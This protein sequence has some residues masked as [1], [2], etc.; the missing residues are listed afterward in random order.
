[1]KDKGRTSANSRERRTKE[2]EKLVKKMEKEGYAKLDMF[3][4]LQII[5]SGIVLL[6]FVNLFFACNFIANNPVY[7]LEMAKFVLS[8]FYA[9]LILILFNV[10]CTPSGFDFGKN[11]SGYMFNTYF[12]S[13][14]YFLLYVKFV[15]TELETVHVFLLPIPVVASIVFINELVLWYTM[16]YV[17]NG[18]K[19]EMGFNWNTFV[20]YRATPFVFTRKR[21]IICNMIP[22]LLYILFAIIVHFTNNI[23]LF[24]FSQLLTFTAA[25]GLFIALRLLLH[26]TKGGETLCLEHPCGEAPVVLVKQNKQ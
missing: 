4:E 16:S 15:N 22:F 21:Y 26:R 3:S 8:M 23:Y 11:Y 18:S 25:N 2:F 24:M 19:I 6:F 9:F 17:T 10:R 20:T 12:L 5:L 1:M 7:N 14:F 13:L